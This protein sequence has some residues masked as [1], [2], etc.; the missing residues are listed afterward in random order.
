MKRMVVF[1]CVLALALTAAPAANAA[2]QKTWQTNVGAAMKDVAV[3]PGGAIYVVG[4]GP[5]GSQ[6]YQGAHAIVSRLTASGDVVWTR[7]WQPHPERPKAFITDAV[8]VA[9]SPTTGVVYVGGTVQRYNCE[10]GGWF[11][12][13]YGPNG[14]FL[15]MSGP[16][17][18][19]YCRPPG[20]QTLT[21]VAVRGNLVVAAVAGTG[22]C[23]T[24]AFVD[25]F[26]RGFTTSLKPLWRSNFEPPAPAKPGWFDIADSVTIA[27]DGTVYAAGWAAIEFSAGETTPAGA[28]LVQRF[29][30]GGTSLWSKRPHV[31]LGN[32]RGV[33]MELLGDRMIVGADLRGGGIWFGALTLRAAQLWHRTW[34]SDAAIRAQMGGVAVDANGR[35]WVV[36]TR[37]DPSGGRNTYVRRYG[38]T[39]MLLATLTIDQKAPWLLGNGVDTLGRTGFV[40]GTR[41]DPAHYRLLHGQV[42]RIDS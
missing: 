6:P 18:A 27:T 10:G 11:I 9:V 3:G 25:G 5:A 21:D 39:G 37:L 15:G 16:Q 31:A 22:C 29:G 2:L 13:A 32:T 28:M 1:A 30:H 33:R 19:W 20:P 26:I 23:G 14:R 17:R 36:G 24:S 34:G 7:G 35:I 8:S 41:Y 12:R 40:V 4:Q 42:W 38:A